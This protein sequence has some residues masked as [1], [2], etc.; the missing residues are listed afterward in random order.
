MQKSRNRRGLKIPKISLIKRQEIWT[1]T[2]PGWIIAIAIIANCAIFTIT[3]I[4]PFLAMNSPVKSAE[5]M[6]IEGWLPD[7][8]LQEAFA[9]F[10]SGNYRQIITT[11]G[12]LELGTYL[13]EY[14]T[15]AD[16]SA[17]TLKKMGLPPDKV[18][19]VSSPMV[20]KD[21]SYASV[22]ELQHW[23][24]QSHLHP[25]SINL[26]SLDVHTR[27]SW[28]VFK[29]ILSPQIQVGAIA[30]KTQEYDPQQWWFYSQGVRSVIYETIA[31]IYAILF[32]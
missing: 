20:I 2:A 9:K 19:A 8:A 32:N 10:Q 5:I 16:L 1:L 3:H 7:Y 15:F 11:G 13:A 26:L 22:I 18:V 23:L 4:H 6:V 21:R 30:T 31:Y 27:R 24:S 12:P 28:L 14:K 29:K 17:A 25:K